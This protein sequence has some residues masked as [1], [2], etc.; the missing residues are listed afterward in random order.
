MQPMVHPDRAPQVKDPQ[1]SQGPMGESSGMCQQ[2]CRSLVPSGPCWAASTMEMV[3]EAR[4]VS[5]QRDHQKP[6]RLGN[7]VAP[8]KPMRG[9]MESISGGPNPR[10]SQGHAGKGNGWK[11]LV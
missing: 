6:S 5:A 11:T 9:D 8:R 7:V 3:P 10:T 1:D 2:G 4:A